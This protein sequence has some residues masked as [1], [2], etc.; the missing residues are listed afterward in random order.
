MVSVVLATGLAAGAPLLVPALEVNPLLA[1]PARALTSA[2]VAQL[3]GARAIRFY[4]QELPEPSAAAPFWGM[5]RFE[6]LQ[7]TGGPTALPRRI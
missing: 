3:I 1:L 7:E 5:T 6:H 4:R 2:T